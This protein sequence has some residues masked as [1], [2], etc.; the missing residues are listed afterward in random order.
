MQLKHRL[1]LYAIVIFSVIILIASGIIYVSFYSQMAKKEAQNLS[2]K[3]V[4]AAIYYLEQ[5]EVPAAEHE[6]TKNQLLKTISRRNIAIFNDKNKRF[7]GDMP[8]DANIS[9]RFMEEIRHKQSADFTDDSY[10][11]HG[12][13]YEDNQGNFIVITRE[14][15]D[16][17]NEQLLSLLKILLVVSLLGIG[18]IYLFSQYLGK[19]AYD[20]VNRI[21]QQIKARDEESFY[22]PLKPEKSYEE[23]H[24]LIATYNHFID[25][26]GQHSQIQKNFIDYVSHE[27][28]TPITAML[29][30]MEVTA[31]QE[32]SAAEYQA[33]LRNLKQYS[34][35]LHETL[36][37][38]MILSGAQDRF[39]FQS[40]RLDEIIWQLV[41][42]AILYHQATI[43]VDI[44]VEDTKLL[45]I[46]ANQKLLSLAIHNLLSNA[47][48]YSNNKPLAIVLGQQDGQL[49]LEVADQ[50]IGILDEDLQHITDNFY[51]GQN[52]QAFQGKGI[53]LSMA[54]IIFNIHAIRMEII[55][56]LPKGTRIQLTFPRF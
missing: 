34:Q 1:S 14:P 31:Q 43:N 2:S 3:S 12:L 51:R 5:D 17:F 6:K 21:I 48:K 49:Y 10:F 46:Q 9:Y 30:S 4:L 33:T 18:L 54:N 42:D 25:R 37:Q 20:P 39:E 56:N 26:I 8:V 53:G 27:L 44:Q 15:K 19:I 35:D 29:G 38:M 7:T 45:E 32:R 13:Y 40:I 50:G 11:Y 16:A 47:I 22:L 52:T 28:R 55:A 23:I 41:E 36:D 24:D